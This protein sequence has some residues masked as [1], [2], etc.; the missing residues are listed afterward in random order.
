MMHLVGIETK[1]QMSYPC[2]TMGEYEIQHVPIDKIVEKTFKNII[3]WENLEIKK[4]NVWHYKQWIYNKELSKA[5][6][7]E[8]VFTMYIILMN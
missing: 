8:V 7:L 4:W 3:I 5:P 1:P 6:F 2:I